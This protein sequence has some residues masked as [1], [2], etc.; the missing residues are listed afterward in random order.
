MPWTAVFAGDTQPLEQSVDRVEAKLEQAGATAQ[1]TSRQLESLEA[2]FKGDKIIKTAEN[3]ATAI[4]KVGGVTKLTAAEQ[5]RAN[6]AIQEAIDKYS[7]LGREAPASIQ[8]LS[9]ELESAGKTG[10]GFSGVLGN[11]KTV[12][13]GVFAGFTVMGAVQGLQRVAGQ[14]LDTAGMLTDL[15]AQTGVSASALDRMRLAAA[16]AGVALDSI[17]NA[18]SAM[19]DKLVSGDKSASS[20]VKSLGLNLDA[21][22]SSKPEDAFLSMVSALAKMPDPM[23]RAKVAFDLF[24]RNAKDVL[25]LVNDEFIENARNGNGWSEDQIKALDDAGDAWAKLGDLAVL[26]SGRII[27]AA[28]NSL[29]AL[30][31]RAREIGDIVNGAGSGSGVGPWT[32]GL[33]VATMGAPGAVLSAADQAKVAAGLKKAEENVKALTGQTIRF[34]EETKKAGEAIK[35]TLSAYDKWVL[36]LTPGVVATNN[37]VNAL[38]A[39]ARAYDMVADARARA[40]GLGIEIQGRSSYLGTQISL[41][42]NVA[43]D[44]MAQVG[45]LANQVSLAGFVPTSNQNTIAGSRPGVNWGGIMSSVPSQLVGIFSQGG[46]SR[47]IGSGIGSLAG[48]VGGQALGS[49]V[50]MAAT[51]VGSTMGSVLGSAIPVIGTVIGGFLGKALGGLF[52]PSKN[53]I[54]T[55]EA[56]GRI[57]QSKAGLLEQFGSVSNIASQG[58]AGEALAAAWNSRGTQGEAWFNKLA[59]E[60]TA[61]VKQQND[62]LAEQT[63]TQQELV[64]LEERRTALAESLK[65]TW[66]QV[67]GLAQKYGL[68]IDGAGQKV[69][70]LGTTASFKAL[71]D[72]METLDRAGWDTNGMLEGMADEISAVVQKSLKWGTEIPANMKPYIEKL[73][74]SGKLVDEN[75]EKITDLSGI[76]WGAPVK[77]EADKVK[78]AMEAITKSMEPMIKRL[79]EIVILLT[80]GLPA[81]AAT[82]AQ[83]TQDAWDR[84][85][86]TFTVDTGDGGQDGDPSTGYAAGGV[87]SRPRRA[88]VGEGGQPEIIGSVDFMASALYHAMARAGTSGLGTGG[89]YVVDNRLELNGH[90]L[91]RQMI[92]IIPEAARRAGVSLPR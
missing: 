63:S 37:Q 46:G 31:A 34:T 14:A 20:S 65:P 49:M 82:G 45:G 72:D 54:A 69:Q 30:K 33:K 60:F 18:V 91:G 8:K 77:T 84:N 58:P 62:L 70:Q 16:P 9:R 41:G 83:Q 36:S 22:K 64:T 56:N 5:T 85:R 73:V 44:R 26:W 89:A 76:K 88:W 71:I 80:R 86:P 35:T 2:S 15:S 23:E 66:E 61:Q 39:M 40:S 1:K 25:K 75:G 4:D 81:A 11:I 32:G 3:M 90:E 17:T 47:Q 6:K 87:V 53:A 24:G 51:A 50:S 52:G 48:S 42:G 12:A 68:H 57:D 67:E 79:D 21:L 43:T 55:K 74:E 13:A 28:F 29:D 92:T 38:N 78:E 59:A 27:S 7:V 19:S 10:T